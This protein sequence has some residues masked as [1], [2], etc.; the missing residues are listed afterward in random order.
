MN[1]VALVR[2]LWYLQT[3]SFANVVRMRIKRLKNPKY[4]VGAV[5]GLA[6]FYQILLRRFFITSEV[7]NQQGGVDAFM[8]VMHDVAPVLLFLFVAM[9]WILAG[10]EATVHFTEAELAF[11]LPAPLTRR[12]L[13]RYSL[14]RGAA[15]TLF[16]ALIF[17]LLGGRSASGARFLYRILGWWLVLNVMRLHSIG[18][19]FAIQRL[20]EEGL[21]SWRRRLGAVILAMAL[22]GSV[23]VWVAMAP[24]APRIGIP[25]A[26]FQPPAPGVDPAENVRRQRDA[27]LKATRDEAS[28]FTAWVHGALHTGPGL[29]LFAPFRWIA[30][31]WF[32]RS[33]G[34]FLKSLLPAFGVLAAH[35]LWVDHSD[36]S[37][38][39]ASQAR[40]R[41]VAEMRA[42][43]RSGKRVRR[44]FK[45]LVP[46]FA[47]TPKGWPGMAFVWRHLLFPKRALA[48]AA[49]VALI[50]LAGPVFVPEGLQSAIGVCAFLMLALIGFLA[51][52][53]A[54]ASTAREFPLF[55]I[56]KTFP[57]PGWHVVTGILV[58]RASLVWAGQALAAA[59][60]LIWFKS[61]FD[62][63][64]LSSSE[65]ICLILGVW[66]VSIPGAMMF[67]VLPTA[68]ALVFPGW[69]RVKNEPQTGFE[70][71]GP[72]L[73]L[74]IGMFVILAVVLLPS[75]AFGFAGWWLGS[76]FVAT[77]AA[78]LA[79]G[80]LASLVVA[81]EVVVG[82]R[83]LGRL[84]E[85]FDV[86]EELQ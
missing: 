65:R 28:K 32:S 78:W 24:P 21:A 16:S 70:V 20:T 34:D 45:A 66:M 13:V 1:F 36:A 85:K 43:M 18:A 6:Y 57:T 42:T 33:F 44:S 71:A 61:P 49:F 60:A 27:A 11:L 83:V 48:I 39:E 67:S 72:R 17:S 58:G 30:E 29:V 79:G 35:F 14:L 25:A 9:N 68:S 10:P 62:D 2:A 5:F 59:A 53:T 50:I 52:M 31:P 41:K 82:L 54:T 63:N 12:W 3:R 55:E 73:L 86:T 69:V 64:G 51:G 80:A 84:F 47:L 40:A 26:E 15:Q 81:A 38:E 23:G 37:F 56:Y 75:A 76:K 74:M 8:G 4:L 22:L 7:A 46:L 77:W 19:S